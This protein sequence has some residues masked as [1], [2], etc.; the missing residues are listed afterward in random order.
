MSQIKLT[1]MYESDS[2]KFATEPKPQH[3][4]EEMFD[5]YISATEPWDIFSSYTRYRNAVAGKQHVT[6]R[7]NLA[8]KTLNDLA[9]NASDSFFNED[10]PKLL[11]SMGMNIDY[12]IVWYA[13]DGRFRCDHNKKMRVFKY[14]RPDHI[15]ELLWSEV[16]RTAPRTDWI[17]CEDHEVHENLTAISDYC[18]EILCQVR[19]RL[20]QYGP[21][22]NSGQVCLKNL[23]THPEFVPYQSNRTRDHRYY[24]YHFMGKLQG[25]NNGRG[26]PADPVTIAKNSIHSILKEY[27]EWLP[28]MR[29]RRKK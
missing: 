26:K 27:N 11:P 23:N 17:L 10:K 8:K 25:G 13:T 12:F 15:S 21:K 1:E 16:L 28:S 2:K 24:K 29:K 19:R 4:I 9:H 6:P 22:T 18:N 5:K 3:V 14:E 20:Q 7:L